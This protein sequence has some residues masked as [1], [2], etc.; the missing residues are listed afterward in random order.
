[1]GTRH[2]IWKVA[3]QPELLAE[4]FL[5]KKALPG[6]TISDD[7]LILSGRWLL[8]GWRSFGMN[9]ELFDFMQTNPMLVELH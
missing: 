2:A 7:L 3:V 9:D 1:M 8:I 5:G 6:Q 4:M